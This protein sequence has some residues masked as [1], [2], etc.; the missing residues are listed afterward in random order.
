MAK[1]SPEKSKAKAKR[2]PTPVKKVTGEF[3][4]GGLFAKPSAKFQKK[5]LYFGSVREWVEAGHPNEAYIFDIADTLIVSGIPIVDASCVRGIFFKGRI[6]PKRACT[7]NTT[8]AFP[9]L[10]MD[11]TKIKQL[12]GILPADTQDHHRLNY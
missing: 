2:Q 1:S 3:V 11:L 8:N 4:L 10:A 6:G 12:D 7:V 5:N 9:M